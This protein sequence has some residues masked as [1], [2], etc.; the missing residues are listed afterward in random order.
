MADLWVTHHRG[1]ASPNDRSDGEVTGGRGITT[2]LVLLPLAARDRHRRVGWGF[3]IH[4]EMVLI[5]VLGTNSNVEIVDDQAQSRLSH[6]VLA[7]MKFEC[8]VMLGAT[9][10]SDMYCVFFFLC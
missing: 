9:F 1:P 10:M 3:L 8:L 4:L 7:V 6:L 2:V 5:A